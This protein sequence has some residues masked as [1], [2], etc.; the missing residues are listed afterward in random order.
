[1]RAVSVGIVIKIGRVS[2]INAWLDSRVGED[3]RSGNGDDDMRSV[4]AVEDDDG[5]RGAAWRLDLRRAGKQG[6][7]NRTA[8]TVS[9][10]SEDDDEN[11][12]RFF[13]LDTGAPVQ[14][15]RL[16]PSGAGRKSGLEGIGDDIVA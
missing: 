5:V 11:T 4:P 10:A 7:L 12:L 6:F 16:L 1:M 9:G 13:P 14:R 8:S 15:L 3:G 2:R